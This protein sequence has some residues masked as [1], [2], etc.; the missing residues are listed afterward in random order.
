MNDPGL[1]VG[2]SDVPLREDTPSWRLVA[3]LS[4]AGVAAGLLIVSVFVATQPRILEHH[5]RALREA[6]QEVLGDPATTET[7]YVIDGA[8]TPDLPQGM[9]SLSVERVFVGY[10]ESGRRL[11]LAIKG[12]EPGFQDVI[13]LIFGYDPVGR[14]LLGMKVLDNKETPGLGDKIVK[15]SAFVGEFVGASAPLVGVK[16]GSG[17]NSENDIDMI[18]GATISSRAVIAIINHQLEAMSPMLDSYFGGGR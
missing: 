11:G 9:D 12:A 10:D 6:V 8:L 14:R 7:L 18:T 13:N 3:T 1:P 2:G 15:D 4:L 16:I 17:S 5:A